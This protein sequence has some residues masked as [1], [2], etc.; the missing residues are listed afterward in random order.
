MP[1]LATPFGCIPRID[2]AHHTASLFR[3]AR[4]ALDK[5]APSG[6]QNAFCHVRVAHQGRDAQIFERN[7]VVALNQSM[8]QFIQEVL[9][10]ITNLLVL[11]LQC[12]NGLPAVAAALRPPRDSPL[13]HAQPPLFRSIPLRVVNLLSFAGREQTGNPYVDADRLSGWWQWSGFHDTR[14][15]GI[16]QSCPAGDAHRLDVSLKRPMPAD[17]NPPNPRQPQPPP[18]DLEAIPIFLEAETGEPIP[19]LKA[20]IAWCVACLHA[21]EE[22][23]EGLVQIGN[24]HLQDMAVDV[25]GVEVERFLNLHLRELLVFSDRLAALLIGIPPFRKALIV[26]AAT[27]F[28]RTLK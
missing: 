20:R 14:E 9:P 28:K 16:P 1:A 6:I 26:L 2:Q 10:P 23:L 25:L 21:P 15:T 8:R 12:A 13:Q 5:V 24:N 17:R 22:R 7:L 11:A 18:I 19:S 4:E 3:F 27:R